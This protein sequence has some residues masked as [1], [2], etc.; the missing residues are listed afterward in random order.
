MKKP[1]YTNFNNFLN[2]FRALEKEYLEQYLLEPTIP[3]KALIM[4]SSAMIFKEYDVK[5]M[6]QY[7]YFYIS[8]FSHI[9]KLFD[10]VDKKEISVQIL[11]SLF[12]YHLKNYRDLSFDSYELLFND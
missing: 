10:P 12:N 6:A 5:K 1:L 2:D 11:K 9:D 7:C 8:L 4:T 3:K